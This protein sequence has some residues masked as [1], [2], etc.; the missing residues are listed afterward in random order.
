MAA[1]VATAPEKNEVLESPQVLYDSSFHNDRERKNPHLTFPNKLVC[2]LSHAWAVLDTGETL[3]GKMKTVYENHHKE[4]I[5]ST[6]L[7]L[8]ALNLLKS[9]C[10]GDNTPQGSNIRP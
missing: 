1:A 8:N 4:K 6:E 10:W 2:N 5:Q 9:T 3:G 7:R